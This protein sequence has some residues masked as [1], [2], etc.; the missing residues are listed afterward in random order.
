MMKRTERFSARIHKLLFVVLF[1]PASLLAEPVTLQQMVE[2]AL[3]HATGVAI[4]AADVQHA[5]AGFRELRNSYIP[6]LTAGAGLGWS[7]GFPLSLEGAAPSLFNVS[8]QSALI[9]PA[10]KYFI[11]AAQSDVTVSNLRT[12]DQRNQVIEDAVLSYAELAKWE[13]R[14]NALRDSQTAAENMEAAVA[15]RVKEGIDSQLDGTRARLS[16][17]RVRLR[18]AEANGAADVLREHLSKLTGLASASVEIDPGSVPAL[19]APDKKQEVA[20]DANPAVQ[21]AVEHA[22]AQYLRVKGEH[23]SLWPSIDFAAQY[24]NLATYNNYQR[25]YQP[26]SFQPNNAT[27]GVAIHFPFVNYAQHARVQEAE[28]E[29]LKARKQAE[30]ARNQIS[31]ETLRL[32]RSVTQM[33][34][35]HDVAE[36]EYEIAQ[37]NIDAVQTRM[38]SGAANLHDLDSARSQASERFIALQDVTFELE[39][40][41]VSLLRASGD[42]EQWAT[43]T[44]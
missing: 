25:F 41:E 10:L 22:R 37:K 42:L 13:Q 30:A 21:A 20:A 12:K 35:A 1:L 8:A 43:G 28:S 16:L 40:S 33:Q 2:L 44:K 7:D 4:A 11:R 18:F 32:Q 6:Q 31:E 9:N 26:H 27:V 14:L 34:A 17:A 23:R 5:S 15:Q 38:N 29:A 39:R 3:K 36:L 24:A 19:P